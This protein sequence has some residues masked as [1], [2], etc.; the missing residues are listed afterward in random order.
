MPYPVDSG[1]KDVWQSRLLGL[2]LA[3]VEVV[4]VVVSSEDASWSKAA[5]RAILSFSPSSIFLF[6]L[7]TR[8]A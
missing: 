3:E 7:L 5:T 1:A 4:G 6:L 8:E 2:D